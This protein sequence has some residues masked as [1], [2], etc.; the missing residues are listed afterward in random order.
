MQAG[1]VLETRLYATSPEE[2]AESST[3]TP[4][5]ASGDADDIYQCMLSML[6]I[7]ACLVDQETYQI[8]AANDAAADILGVSAAHDLLGRSVPSLVQPHAI[9]GTTAYL[10]RV[11]ESPTRP[12]FLHEPIDLA[13]GRHAELEIA[14]GL[15][16]LSGRQVIQIAFRDIT[17][18]IKAEAALRDSV[19][20]FRSLTET[21][22][23]AIF[24]F[25]GARYLHVNPAACRI[26]GYTSEELAAMPFWEIVHPDYREIVRNRGFARQQRQEV[27]SNYEVAIITKTGETRWLQFAGNLIDYQGEPAV[28]GTAIDITACKEVEQ[29][30]QQSEARFR[31]L[32]HVSPASI[33]I[34]V[35]DRLIYANPATVS[36]TGF[37]VE[38]LKDA[39]FWS[40]LHPDSLETMRQ[41]Y[42]QMSRGEAVANLKLQIITKD[43]STKWLEINWSP[44]DLNGKLAWVITSYDVTAL[45]EAGQALRRYARRLEALSEIDRLGLMAMTR[46]EIA[47]AA[48]DIIRD[49]IPCDRASIVEVDA[50]RRSHILLAVSPGATTKIG[51]GRRFKL[52]N[53]HSVHDSLA[54][55]VYHIP[56]LD[57]VDSPSALQRELRTEGFRSYINVPMSAQNKL[58]GVLNL[59]SCQANAFDD[60]LQAAALE[61]GRRL[62]T[63]MHMA[64]L[65][66]QLD[67]SHQRLEEMSRR[68]VTLQEAERRSIARELH[69]EVGQTLTA[70][71]IHLELA[72][73]TGA[74][75]QTKHLAETQRLVEDLADRIRR[76]SLDLRPPMLDDLGLLPTLLWCFER[77][78]QQYQLCVNFEHR[79]IERRFDSE[80]ETAVFRIV[81]EALTN[82]A[83]HAQ[84][85]TASVR[86]WADADTI[87]A[88][89]EDKGAGFD[90]GFVL[91]RNS[92]TGLSG[93][94][95][96]ARLL[97]G[98]LVIDAQPGAG[99]CLTALLPLRKTQR[100]EH[101]A[102]PL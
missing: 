29:A 83:R 68:L 14:T 80:V 46:Q 42:E 4:G 44:F 93:M 74:K 3:Q 99:A 31:T 71:S 39:D 69:D 95:E 102:A 85:S 89:I 54:R 47:S 23:A 84:V 27:E 79:G 19:A 32:T 51:V 34:H 10:R 26:T 22:D 38:E 50:A 13:S 35:D 57:A 52:T 21:T 64:Q 6:P 82:V 25:R 91:R 49:L 61:I 41:A 37:S 17:D 8:L 87:S 59:G 2:A 55:G 24:L 56:D 43:G 77:M 18:R 66:E 40:M 62:A 78:A 28:L 7:G 5:L 30:L 67:N 76:M 60:T 12:N 73:S 9:A 1:R 94:Q 48:L 72:S 98:K 101:G 92:S 36:L 20:L 81:Q 16:E 33:S 63:V 90:P 75:D 45:V 96:R 70:L 65:F 97:K 86:L 53:W 88:Q 11:V 100:A 58:V 15:L